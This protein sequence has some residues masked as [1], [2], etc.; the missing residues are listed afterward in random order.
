MGP[1]LKDTPYLL[2]KDTIDNDFMEKK[3]KYNGSTNKNLFFN[4]V[5][6]NMKYYWEGIFFLRNRTQ[7]LCKGTV[8]N[9]NFSLWHWPCARDLQK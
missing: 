2:G 7:E 6:P 3:I 4:E 8:S 5:E 9:S 1:R